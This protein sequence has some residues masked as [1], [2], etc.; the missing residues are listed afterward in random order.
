MTHEPDAPTRGS[1][2][3]SSSWEW[4]RLFGKPGKASSLR[5]MG[6]TLV[7]VSLIG[8]ADY[9][10]GVELSLLIFYFLPVA[11]AVAAVGWLFGVA[12]AVLSVGVWLVSDYAAGAHFANSFVPV[13]NAVI[14]L[15]TY[16]VMIWLLAK[17]LALHR[18]METRVKARTADLT[19]EIAERQR[20][21][22]TVLE[23]SERERRAIGHDLH[24]GLGQHLTGTALVAQAL[25]TRLAQR[26]VPEEAEVQRIVHLI[27]EGIDQTRA[28]AKGLLLAEIEDTGLVP[29]LEELALGMRE[30]FGVECRLYCE[31][32]P[33]LAENG[34]ATQLYRIA[35]EAVRN[36]LRHG[37]AGTV[38]IRIEAD[39]A[40][41]R[42]A[43]E[44]DGVGLPEP[45][46]R[47]QGLG[48]RIMA[49][50]AS[51]IGARFSI[52]PLHGKGTVVTCTLP[53][54]RQT[55]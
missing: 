46:K 28:L 4:S 16:L 18:Q 41:L 15:S 50:R 8:I 32:P 9:A 24:D 35:Q 26:G 6:A 19:A 44:D 20:L 52:D 17:L 53:L 5:R 42:L 1:K 27:E 12:T 54:E 3:A 36:A 33:L 37:K 43:I 30:Q 22:R 34:A 23:I 13:W 10:T 38:S 14:A 21:E 55:L 2:G 47:G 49:H 48:L 29:A 31:K 11:F 51:I 39:E 40:N 25:R 7:L 45:S